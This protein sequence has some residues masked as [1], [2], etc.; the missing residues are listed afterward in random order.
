MGASSSRRVPCHGPEQSCVA[1]ETSAARRQERWRS[2]P[3]AH[4]VARGGRGIQPT[5][6]NLPAHYLKNNEKSC[7]QV[8]RPSRGLEPARAPTSASRALPGTAKGPWRA[9]RESLKTRES[10]G[11]V[12]WEAGCVRRPASCRGPDPSGSPCGILRGSSGG[13]GLEGDIS[14]AGPAG[15]VPWKPGTPVLRAAHGRALPWKKHMS[16]V[17]QGPAPGRRPSTRRSLRDTA[18]PHNLAAVLTG[19]SRGWSLQRTSALSEGDLPVTWPGG[20]C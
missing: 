12:A 5:L 16:P 9:C 2:A 11:R 14:E 4:A 7:V 13:G 6:Q 10:R 18:S 19:L 1:E 15:A 20:A 8:R 3:E 17:F